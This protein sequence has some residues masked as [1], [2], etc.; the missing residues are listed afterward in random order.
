M[1]YSKEQKREYYLKTKEKRLQKRNENRIT[2]D[3]GVRIENFKSCID[4]HNKTW[5]HHYFVG[6]LNSL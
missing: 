5:T 3:C 4:K 2:C 6:T 1:A